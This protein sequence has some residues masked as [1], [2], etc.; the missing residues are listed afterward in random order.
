[1]K[2]KLPFTRAL[3]HKEFT[4]RIPEFQPNYQNQTLLP[5]KQR[6]ST[7]ITISSPHQEKDHKR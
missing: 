3:G 6:I 5:Y 7:D 2:N 1:M 4:L